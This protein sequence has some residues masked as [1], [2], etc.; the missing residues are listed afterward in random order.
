MRPKILANVSRIANFSLGDFHV[1]RSVLLEGR[2]QR[3]HSSGL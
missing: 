1:V 2:H 3:D